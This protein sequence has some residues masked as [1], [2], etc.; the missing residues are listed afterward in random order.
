MKSPNRG[1]TR[2]EPEQASPPAAA[3]VPKARS[4]KPKSGRESIESF[5]V[6]F[7]SFLIWSLEAEG[8]RDPDRLDGPDLDGTPQGN[9]LPAVRLHVY[10]QRRS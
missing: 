3:A 2:P 7:V 1:R 8:L 10:G 4:R 5:V 9:R 6:V